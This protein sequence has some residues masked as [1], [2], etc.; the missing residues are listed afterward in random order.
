MRLHGDLPDQDMTARWRFASI[1][2]RSSRKRSTEIDETKKL[3]DRREC[4]MRQTI[5]GFVAG[6]GLAIAGIAPAMA[7]GGFGCGGC[8]YAEPCAPPDQPIYTYADT[9]CGACGGTYERL[10]EPAPEYYPTTRY[11]YVNQGPTYSGPG[12]FAPYPSYQQAAVVGWGYR[13]HPYYYSGAGVAGPAV[14][15]YRGY[16]HRRPAY[17]HSAYRWGHSTHY[18]GRR[19]L[20]RYY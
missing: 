8:F 16:Y 14:Y 5:L 9:G 20:R 12:A 15:S 13:H 6:I 7:C 2:S 4:V 17:R 18:H 1:P 19:V 3:V 11:Y 10:A